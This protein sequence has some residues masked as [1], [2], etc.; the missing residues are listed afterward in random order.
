MDVSGVCMHVRIC[1]HIYIC[2]C[3]C[4]YIYIFTYVSVWRHAHR[5]YLYHLCSLEGYYAYIHVYI[6][7]YTN[8]HKYIY[9]YICIHQL[10]QW[11]PFW[12]NT[13]SAASYDFMAGGLT[14]I[15]LIGLLLAIKKSWDDNPQQVCSIFVCVYV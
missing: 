6:H 4:V 5:S 15:G 2:V 13:E 10:C 14:L 3:V 8:T 7:T 1:M 9:I 11:E 12:A